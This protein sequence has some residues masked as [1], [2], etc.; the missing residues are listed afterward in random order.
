VILHDVSF[1]RGR[2]IVVSRACSITHIIQHINITSSASSASPASPKKN[3]NA[4]PNARQAPSTMRATWL[5]FALVIAFGYASPSLT[6]PDDGGYDGNLHGVPGDD[7][8]AVRRRCSAA[9]R[10]RG[11]G[12]APAFEKWRGGGLLRWWWR[13][14][15]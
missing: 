6:S 14:A 4:V 9:A 1:P 8:A 10:R 12:G 2:L 7:G 5:N 13:G 15:Q 11:G 3:K